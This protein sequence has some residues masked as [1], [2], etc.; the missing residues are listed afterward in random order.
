M[1]QPISH[2]LSHIIT[3]SH[4][5]FDIISY[6]FTQVPLSLKS[7]STVLS[8]P[9]SLLQWQPSIFE[10]PVLILCLHYPAGAFV[11]LFFFALIIT[12]VY[13][14][15]QSD[16]SLLSLS[17]ARCPFVLLNI[18]IHGIFLGYQT[19]IRG[20]R[21]KQVSYLLFSLHFLLVG[22]TCVLFA[23]LGKLSSLF[24]QPSMPSYFCFVLPAAMFYFSYHWDTNSAFVSILTTPYAIYN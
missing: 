19:A 4:I 11:I 13:Y 20:P 1:V 18:F 17:L 23:N 15:Q 3:L 2:P 5:S 16:C 14:S 10:F 22:Q 21:L 7:L 12:Y 24:Q 8:R 9:A 6:T